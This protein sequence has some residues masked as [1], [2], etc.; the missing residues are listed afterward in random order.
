MGRR[1]GLP[2]DGVLL[3]DKPQGISS[4]AALQRVRRAFGAAKAGHTGTLDPMAQGLLPIA[5]GEA[6]KFTQ[7]L[8]DA[9]KTYL[10]EIQLGVV[11]DTGDAEGRVIEQFEHRPTLDEIVSA[12]GR[13][14]GPQNQIPPIY[15]ALKHEG[16]PLY[17]YARAGEVVE[18]PARLVTIHA[19]ELLEASSPEKIRVRVR[20]SKGTYIR[21]LAMDL[22]RDLGCG[23]HLTALTREAT[24]PFRLE[25]AVSLEA[26]EAMATKERLAL[27]GPVE[28]FAQHLPILALPLEL[29]AKI[30]FG[31]SIQYGR[32]EDSD[33]S[34][35]NLVRLYDNEAFFGIGRLSVAG[36]L[37]PL[38]LVAS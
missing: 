20:C 3:L 1:K 9:D 28:T 29:A 23:G 36:E 22:G 2:I 8:L 26:L 17:E 32:V 15:S 25:S 34:E 19:M 11:T 5:L 14:I 12:C 38:R 10:A 16:K 27:L 31:Q 37:A 33:P 24:G 6:T 21:V 7:F 4:N 13:W 30:R 35:E 18:K